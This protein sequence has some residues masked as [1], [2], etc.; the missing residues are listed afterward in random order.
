[1]IGSYNPHSET[2]AAYRAEWVWALP[3]S[4]ATTQGIYLFSSSY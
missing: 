3:V 1:M 2:A 4:L